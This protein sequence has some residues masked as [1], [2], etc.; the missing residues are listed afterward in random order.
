MFWSTEGLLLGK[1]LAVTCKPEDLS[2]GLSHPHKKLVGMDGSQEIK[3]AN[4][5]QDCRKEEVFSMA[6]NV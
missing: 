6:G 2:S 4:A 5:G 3:Q 1:V